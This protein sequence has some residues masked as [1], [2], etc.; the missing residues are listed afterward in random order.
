MQIHWLKILRRAKYIVLNGFSR[1]LQPISTFLVSF[2]IIRFTSVDFWG[3]IVYLLLIF[4]FGFN[5]VNWGNRLYLIREFSLRPDQMRSAWLQSMLSRGPLLALFLLLVAFLEYDTSI[6]IW[7]GLWATA[8]FG[9][10]SFEPLVTFEKD[11]GFAA[12]NDLAGLVLIIVPIIFLKDQLDLELIVQVYSIATIFKCA[13][14]LV[15]YRHFWGQAL[16]SSG[17][18][19][20]SAPGQ[21]G[22][23]LFAALPFMFLSLSGMLQQRTDLYCVALIL[24][25]QEVGRYQVF[26]NFLAFS[27]LVASLFLSPFARNIYRLKYESLRKLERNFIFAGIGIT[28]L[29][30]WFTYMFMKHLYN[31]EFSL[32][33]YILG[34][35][36][37]FL[38]YVYLIRNFEYGRHKR[39]NLVAAY[40]LAGGIANLLGSL[41]LTPIYGLEGALLAGIF[42]QALIVV[43]F[44][45][46]M[47]FVDK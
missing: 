17:W 2:L 21:I 47:P 11:F 32:M 4:E 30:L 9:F 40:S 1:A 25:A 13:I 33:L 20:F 44:Y 24:E 34:Y 19:T 38:F 5:L 10:Q 35:L 6:L 39:Q 18:S 36:Y 28:L 15:R 26:T 41:A 43:L 31:F 8:R 3:Q 12:L 23:W 46:K 45:R 29:C 14:I 16:T 7:L 37:V 42:S 27:Q 22:P